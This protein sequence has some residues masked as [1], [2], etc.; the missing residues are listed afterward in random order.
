MRRLCLLTLLA[1]CG[2]NLAKPDAHEPP[3]DDAAGSD[4]AVTAQVGITLRDD[5][6]AIDVTA[7]GSTA[8]FER[9]EGVTATVVFLDTITG[10]ASDRTTLPDASVDLAT[11]V[12]NDL[13]ISAE[14]DNPVGGGIYTDAAGTWLDIPTPFATGCDV[15][16]GGAFDISGDGKVATGLL[17]NGCETH[18]FRWEDTGGDGTTTPLELLGTPMF[19]SKSNRGSVVSRDGK[20]IAGFAATGDADRTPAMWDEDGNGTFLDPTNTSTPGE[21]LSTNADGSILGGT[22]G[23]QAFV[24][25]S[26]G[27]IVLLPVFDG[28]DP[29]TSGFVNA[30]SGDGTQLFG[31][32]GDDFGL[33]PATAVVWTLSGASYEAKT[34]AD[35][36]AAAGITVPAGFH[37]TNITG[38]SADGTVIVGTAADDNFHFKTFVLRLPST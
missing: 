31:E 25:T 37:L 8:V 27:G 13:R 15:F 35:V 14:Y 23:N 19:G 34:L 24:W 1:A 11:G 3:P 5:T 16:T 38:A 10:A 29:S 28:A 21:V 4:A 18:A 33:T 6:Y 36:V 9:V 22:L 12:S 30:T 2:D 26:A 17:N 32:V 20:V 7:D